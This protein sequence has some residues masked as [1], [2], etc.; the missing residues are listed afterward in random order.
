MVTFYFTPLN[1]KCPTLHFSLSLEHIM[2]YTKY[3][4]LVFSSL[5]EIL[6]LISSLK[7]APKINTKI[8]DIELAPAL[9]PVTTLWHICEVTQQLQYAISDPSH[10]TCKWGILNVCLGRDW[11]RSCMSG[12]KKRPKPNVPQLIRWLEPWC[13][14]TA[15][16]CSN[17]VMLILFFPDSSFNLETF[18]KI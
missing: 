3:H 16:D 15:K 7:E 4:G 6:R 2:Q 1:L 13:W 12:N 9:S 14:K 5:A 8:K 18:G 17:S 11:E 10:R